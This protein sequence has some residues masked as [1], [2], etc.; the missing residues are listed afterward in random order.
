[1]RLAAFGLALL[2]TAA[3]AIACSC[4]EPLTPQDK[5]EIAARIARTAAAVA[6]VEMIAA[7]DSEAMRGE[8]YRV[9]KVHVGDAPGQ[10]ELDRGFTRG[11]AGDVQMVMTSC[12]VVPPPGER[13]TV[14]L[15]ATRTAGRM[16]IG[17]SCD[18]LFVN[19]PGA[20]ELIRASWSAVRRAAERG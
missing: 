1:M 20:V 6:D 5:S 7:R 13:T 4:I 14:L 8:T 19:T 17:D 9:L 15:F 12:D 18:H 2:I 11:P 10:F 16:R 3:P